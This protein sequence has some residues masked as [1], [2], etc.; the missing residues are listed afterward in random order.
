MNELD[1]QFYMFIAVFIVIA[2]LIT[3]IFQIASIDK[4]VLA[5]RVAS[6]II[7]FLGVG[8]VIYIGISFWMELIISFVIL[9]IF[10]LLIRKNL[11]VCYQCNSIYLNQGSYLKPTQFCPHCGK[12]DYAI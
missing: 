12:E 4:K 7:P 1:K 11:R 9:S 8:Y 5:I 10:S 6:I 2:L 3:H